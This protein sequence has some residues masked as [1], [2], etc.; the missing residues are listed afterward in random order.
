MIAVDLGTISY[1][2]G[3]YYQEE[4]HT[5]KVKGRIDDT[6]FLLEHYPVITIGKSGGNKD[7]LISEEE[8]LKR[9]VSVHSVNRGGKIT[10]HYPGQL[11]AYPVVSLNRYGNDIHKFV[12]NLEDTIIRT[13]ADFGISGRRINKLRGI[14]VGNDKIA[15]IGIEIRGWVSMH[16]ISMNIMEDSDLYSFFVP[17]GITDKGVTSLE[18]CLGADTGIGMKMIKKRF[19]HHFSDIFD[20]PIRKVIPRR[21]FEKQYLLS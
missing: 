13:L 7:L 8:L 11:V 5:L 20:S 15:S 1:E 16:G 9:G 10:C 17:C 3:L 19:L 21:Q 2:E 4:T 14:F 12:Y 6:V 18:S